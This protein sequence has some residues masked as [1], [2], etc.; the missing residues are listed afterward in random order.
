MSVLEKVELMV[1]LNPFLIRASAGRSV[2]VETV[3][4]IKS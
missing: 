1:G 3:Q 4:E 2:N